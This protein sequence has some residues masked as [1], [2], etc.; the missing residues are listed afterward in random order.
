MINEE[1]TQISKASNRHT[2]Y[3]V[4]SSPSKIVAIHYYNNR[5]RGYYIAWKW[6]V[7]AQNGGSHRIRKQ[8]LKIEA[9]FTTNLR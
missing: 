6:L 4:V 9:P 3:P 5:L 8:A 1:A 2:D 7:A